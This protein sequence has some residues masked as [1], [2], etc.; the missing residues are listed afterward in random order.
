MTDPV[1]PEGM[2]TL[3]GVRWDMPEGSPVPTF[4]LDDA[5]GARSDVA[6]QAYRDEGFTVETY[7]YGYV[8]GFRDILVPRRIRLLVRDGVVVDARQG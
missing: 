2:T 4:P 8:G 6:S 7:P 3:G 5:I 1:P